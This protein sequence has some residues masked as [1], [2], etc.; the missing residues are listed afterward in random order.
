V[1]CRNFLRILCS[2]SFPGTQ[3]ATQ[4]MKENNVITTTGNERG[5]NPV[6]INRQG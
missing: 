1:L 6:T 2:T 3:I 4:I 5:S